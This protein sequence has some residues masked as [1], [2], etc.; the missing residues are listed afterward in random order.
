MDI[1]LIVLGA[2]LTNNI[3]LTTFSGDLSVHRGLWGV[4]FGVGDG[5]GGHLR[6][7]DDLARS[8]G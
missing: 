7:D 4:R 6:A 8:I 5:H 2:I 1:F 3:L